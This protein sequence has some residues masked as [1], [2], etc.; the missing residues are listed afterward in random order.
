MA[1]KLHSRLGMRY[2]ATLGMLL[3]FPQGKEGPPWGRPHF[4]YR[5]S[6]IP[7]VQVY[8]AAGLL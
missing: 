5:F 8:E 3:P 4:S 1:R 6:G 7:P 2:S